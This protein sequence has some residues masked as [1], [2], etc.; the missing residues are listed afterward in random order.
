MRDQWA[1]P[2]Q[3]DWSRPLITAFYTDFKT[4]AGAEAYASLMLNL[5]REHQP[6]PGKSGRSVIFYRPGMRHVAT[7]ERDWQN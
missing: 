5:L 4:R 2:S 3:I 1:D 6:P 7:L